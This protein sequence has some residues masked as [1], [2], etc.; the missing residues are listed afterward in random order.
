MILKGSQRASGGQLA[1]HL[2]ND[3]D[4][5][6]V[7]LYE[8]RG[9]AARDLHGAFQEAHAVSKGTRCQQYLFSLSISPPAS[10]NVPEQDFLAAIDQA[11]AK[12]GLT[13]HPRAIVFHEKEGRRHAHAVW[14]RI[15][16]NTMTAVRLSHFKT[17]LT[18]LSRELYLEHGWSLPDGLRSQ[19]SRSPL[20]F[21]LAE[22]QQAKRSKL[23]PREIKIAFQESWQRSDSRKGFERALEERGYFLAKGDRRGFVAVD[24]RGEVYSVARYSGVKT[25]EVNAKLGD[26]EQLPT[27]DQVRETISQRLT[28]KLGRFADQVDAR[29]DA[30]MAPLIAERQSMTTAHRKERKRLVQGQKDRWDRE[31]RERADRL[32]TGLRGL[33]QRMSGAAAKVKARNLEEALAATERDRK[34]KDAL[35]EAQLTERRHLQKRIDRLRQTHARDRRVLARDIMIAMR[36]GR[37]AE[38]D[39]PVP[40]R[41]RPYRSRAPDLTP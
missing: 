7:E 6:H 4:N 24:T 5:D 27:V 39:P 11:E 33:W 14:S 1:S 12:L 13:G 37:G 20:N 34:Q 35:I 10:E 36:M 40:S 25:R 23:D 21:T 3:R 16:A 2:L 26:T 18:S 30:Q 41:D 9:F 28:G 15:D 38:H 19:A 31:A 29:H 32:N 17:K 22:W 8:V